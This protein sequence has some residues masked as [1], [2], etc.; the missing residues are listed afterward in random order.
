[1]STTRTAPAAAASTGTL[2][3]EREDDLHVLESGLVS[4][5]DGRGSLLAVDGPIGIGKTTLLQA[6][7]ALARSRGLSVF[8][9]RAAALEQEFSYGVVRQLYA[10]LGLERGDTAPEL[11]KGAAAHALRAFREGGQSDGIAREG[12][13]FATLH[14]LYWFTADLAGGAPLLLVVDDCHWADAPSLRFLGHLARRLDGLPVLL[15]VARRTG[16]SPGDPA[17]LDE[18]LALAAGTPI[19][20]APLGPAAVARLVRTVLG[21]DASDGFCGACYTATGGN[22]LLLRTL[23]AAAA[24]DGGRPDDEHAE[25]VAELAAES[26]GRLLARQLTRLPAGCDGVVRALAVLGAGAPLRQVAALAGIDL[27]DA[28]EDVDSLRAAGVLAAEPPLDFAHPVL[29]AAA[30]DTMTTAERA[31]AHERAVELL[32]A[33]GAP[34]DRL[35]LHLLHTHP[36]GDREVV[37]TLRAAAG[38]AADRG[39]P[40]TAGSYLR[41]ALEESPPPAERAPLLLELGLALMAAWRDPGAPALLEEAIRLRERPEEK[42]EAA[43]LAGRAL[44]FQSA[45][46]NAVRLLET[47]IAGGGLTGERARLAEGEL[48]AHSSIM[49]GCVAENDARL[50]RYAD[51]DPAT[52]AADGVLSIVRAYRGFATMRDVDAVGE[53]I[54]RALAGPALQSGSV[55]VTLG[56]LTLIWLDRLDVAE[57][58][59]ARLV[60]EGE[61]RGDVGFVGHY[62]WTRGL[63]FAERGALRDAE[64][65]ARWVHELKIGLRSPGGCLFTLSALL[66]I[67][68]DGGRLAA[69]SETLEETERLLAALDRPEEL[70]EIVCWPLAIEQRGRLRID[71]GALEQGLEDLEEAHRCWDALGVRSPIGARWREYAVPALVRLGEVERARSLAA[72]ELDLAHATGVARAVGIAERVAAPTEPRERELELLAHAVELLEPTPARL[73]HARAL[74]DFG[75]ALRRAGKRRDAQVQLRPALELAHRCG[76]SGLAAR[77][78][79]ELVAA[80][81]RPRRPVF[82]GLES[83]TAAERRVARHAAD[84]HSNREI[85]ETLFITQRTVETHLRHTFQKLGIT[86]RSELPPEL[87]A[88]H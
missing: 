74:V 67:L 48:A 3:L 22:P 76:A 4:A 17:L 49:A 77:A 51:L 84:G 30:G 39:A 81:A 78:R 54:E 66:G 24:E 70:E 46:G 71:L 60:A 8:T 50:A 10:P 26:T 29:R 28:A 47:G 62:S 88:A 82:T 57:T 59:S 32:A 87:A 18:L 21:A 13:S 9:A 12:I 53:R 20:P 36:R 83:L 58:I 34:A 23:L 16:E 64:S 61:R 65:E 6:A 80:G 86:S 41:R 72:E 35:A 75:A 5:L 85:A 69:A 7:A 33:E 68:L 42:L 45:V 31:R 55:A 73:E 2:L 15:L 38:L 14:G 27:E 44:A 56:L 43:L 40:D 19:R 79:E 37:A 1:M 52:S 63:A 11:F 25:H